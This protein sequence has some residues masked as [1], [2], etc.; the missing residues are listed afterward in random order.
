MN[1]LDLVQ[2]AW[3]GLAAKKARTAL[4]ICGPVLG[5]AALVGVIGLTASA[6]GNIQEAIQS[7]GTNLVVVEAPRARGADKLPVESVSRAKAVNTV[8][9][10]TGVAEL[11]GL[12][13]SKHVEP[14]S[15]DL[16]TPVQVRAADPNLLE[17]IGGGVSSGRFLSDIDVKAGARAVVLGSEVAQLYEVD[18]GETR[19]VTINGRLYGIVGVLAPF[20]VFAELNRSVFITPASAKDDWGDDGRPSK[21]YV[22]A[23]DGTTV[24]TAHILPLAL[25]LGG[26]G[27]AIVSIPSDLLAAQ[28]QVDETLRNSGLALAALALIVS[29]LG[30][31]NLM[32]M[33][34]MQRSAEIGVRRALG[35]R[36]SAIALQFVLEALVIGT[37]GG[38]I[39]VITG[40][41]F[42]AVVAVNRRWAIVL[43]PKSLVLG[44]FI[45]VVVAIVAA[46]YPALRAA[47]LEPLSVLRTA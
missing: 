35:H 36:R 23:I 37:L 6:K 39:G 4:I 12:V 14:D 3:Q 42:V 41:L 25:T 8:V 11:S 26:P 13:V 18:P 5:V 40:S 47:R 9:A 2:V 45:A 16:V 1:A 22:R 34:V 19:A 21:L 46:T 32:S 7:L 27:S 28:A 20:P 24:D 29:G 10:V 30:I 38:T 44:F 33:S 43:D 17:V 31:A 15:S